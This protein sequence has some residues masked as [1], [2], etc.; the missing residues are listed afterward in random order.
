MTVKTKTQVGV[1]NLQPTWTQM[2]GGMIAVL[3]NPNAKQESLDAVR[4]ELFRLA[5]FADD[6]NTSQDKEAA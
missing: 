4:D 2:M 6:F 3:Q 1:I 5:K